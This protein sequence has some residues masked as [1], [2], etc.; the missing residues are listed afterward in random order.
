MFLDRFTNKQ[1]KAGKPVDTR[2]TEFFS[3]EHAGTEGIA[4]PV[5]AR[6][7]HQGA[8]A[9]VYDRPA[10]SSLASR[11]DAS[12]TEV[13]TDMASLPPGMY[14]NFEV[15]DIPASFS[16]NFA[17]LIAGDAFRCLLV[18]IEAFATHSQFELQRR[19]AVAGMTNLVI[20]KATR[21]IIQAIHATNTSSTGHADVQTNIES[22]AWSLIDSAIQRCASDIH[23]ETR[24]HLTQVFYRIHG[25]RVEQPVM[26]TQ[27]ATEVCNVLYSVHGDADNKGTSW[28]P[29][30][31][32]DTVIEYTSPDGIMSQLRFSS[33]PIH[34]AGNFHAVIRV[35]VMDERRIRPI[36][37]C[38]YTAEQIMA[39]EDML[40]GAHGA[41]LLVG[42]TN[43]GKSTSMQS[44]LNRIFDRRGRHIKL[45][46][47]ERPVEYIVPGGCQMGVPQ[48]RRN[49]ED[50]T[51][52]SVY[53]TFLKGT[54]RQDP[55]VVMVGEIQ[56]E[57][58]AEAVKHLVL[59]GR[60]LLTTLHAFE[61]MAVFERLREIGVPPSVLFMNGFISGV[62]YQRLV[63]LLCDR[64]ALPLEEARERGRI[65][66]STYERVRKV[67]D[68]AVHLVRTRG[69]GCLYCD[70]TG[71]IGRTLCAEV[72]VPD[73]KL[74]NMLKQGAE[75]EAREYWMAQQNLNIDGL[76][77]GVIA[78]AIHK[79]R[80][81][82][83][84]PSDVESQVGLIAP[85]ASH[86]F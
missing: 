18:A 82:L 12:G 79:M 5:P 33:G 27:T 62:I 53:T 32:M 50:K 15:N 24:G 86:L 29:K 14:W 84:D 28:D 46:T 76:G 61:S 63:P 40:I 42:P 23:I 1:A 55:D 77:V 20:R 80:R 75:Q 7:A 39:I 64:C 58:S 51:T 4:R 65:A 11:R 72:L 56:D 13:I 85:Q 68:P 48:G 47:V 37:D 25:E 52:G 44:F 10:A 69:D 22:I 16:D 60:K 41:V 70:H 43:G 8:P 73:A 38:G 74:L 81:G 71:V 9:G 45:I 57:E 30:Q 2:E 36:E 19:L 21:E 83:L 34:P 6:D 3:P 78:H 59:A 66:P 35:L 31:L 49:L 17:V 26:S 54:L 67:T